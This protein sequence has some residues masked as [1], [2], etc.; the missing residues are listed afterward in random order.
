MKIKLLSLLLVLT[1]MSFTFKKEGFVLYDGK[2]VV[3]IYLAENEPKPLQIAARHLQDDIEMVTGHKP[4]IITNKSKLKGDVI[5]LSTAK[6]NSVKMKDNKLDGLY[7]SFSMSRISDFT[8]SVDDAILV[9][10]S[11]ALGAVYGT[12][13]ISEL[14]GVSPLYWW[15]DIKPERKDKVV[16]TEYTFAPEQPAVRYRAIFINDEEALIKW[17]GNTS[18]DKTK[19]AISPETYKKIF[20][21]MLRTRANTLWPSMMEAGS[22]FFE[23]KDENGIPI[24]PKNATDYGVYIGTSHCENMAR[25][26]YAEWYEW[27]E[28]HKELFDMNLNNRGELEFD[29]TVNPRAIEIYWRERIEES[30]NFNMIYTMGIRGVHDSPFMYRLMENPTLEKRVALLQKV[31]DFQRNMIKEVFGSEDAVPQ[32][33]VPYEETAELYNGESKDGKEKCES[34]K[35]PE[36]IMIV[37]TEDNYSYLRQLPKPEEVKRKGG[38]G[39]YYHLAYQ[40]YPSPY[41]WLTTIPYPNMQQE[42]K[43][44]YEAGSKKFWIVNVGDIKPC[45]V[46]L[47]LFIKMA[48]QPKKY[49]YEPT[50][51]YIKNT[52]ANMLNLDEQHTNEVADIVEKFQTL[53]NSNKPEFVTCFWSVYFQSTKSTYSFFSPFDFGDEIAQT[54]SAYKSLESRAK[55]VYDG[56]SE[57]RKAPFW[58][59]VYY[60][61]RAARQM[62]EKGYYYHKNVLYSEQG[63]FS[64]VNGYKALSERAAKEIDK[65]L[66][67]YNKEFLNGKWNGITDPYGD[68]NITERVFDIAGIIEH[69]IYKEKFTEESQ[70]ALG[71]VC[72]GQV[73]GKEQMVLRF[74]SYEDNKRFVDVFS[75]GLET[76]SWELVPSN[77]WI[78][79]NKTK[80]NVESEERLWVSIDWTK[81]KVG[82]N[83]GSISVKGKDGEVNNFEVSA[84]KFELS[85]KPKSYVE[86]AGFVTIEAEDYSSLRNGKGN[87]TWYEVDKLGYCGSS[88]V[89][90]SNGKCNNP[91]EEGA[92]LS[93]NVYFETAGEFTGYVYRIP[94]LNEGKGKTCNVAIGVDNNA[95]QILDGIRAKTSFKTTTMANG[96]KESRNWAKNVA[97]QMEKLPFVFKI[98][99][100]GYHT[101]SLYA[102]DNHIAVDRVVIATNPQSWTALSRSIVGPKQSYNNIASNYN[103]FVPAQNATLCKEDIK[104]NSYPNPQPLIYSKFAFSRYGNPEVWGFTP[105]SDMNIFKEGVNLYG[106]DKH[107]VKNVITGHNESTRIVPHWRRDNNRGNNPATFYVSLLEGNYEITIHSGMIRYYGYGGA[108]YDIHMNLTANGQ[109]LMNNEFFKLDAP[110][111]RT[112]NIKVGRDNLLKLDFSGKWCVSAIEIYRK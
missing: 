54:I 84:S 9:V 101:I 105:V 10:G 78:K 16:L 66:N 111:S 109:Q 52:Y 22:Y 6:N 65:D 18:I 106:W 107:N 76:Q 100:P 88:M 30:K 70:D 24:N 5:I 17:S 32:I 56:L 67:Y 12:F 64:A 87:A 75:K 27:A 31:I 79:I 35:L 102:V 34:L 15:G 44:V 41:D 37:Y 90:K 98:D 48:S 50:D 39:I 29:Y 7:E 1:L 42:L 89:V 103:K 8:P 40:G 99:K 20:E 82:T 92:T 112:Y 38:C 21:M 81:A 23:F 28:N 2:Q 43:K 97:T 96:K 71:S 57:N 19:G 55:R 60:P 110:S 68:Y 83:K 93:Y 73:N 61:I 72:E 25:N 47:N 13:Q 62:I 91:K 36:D 69:F 51:N 80:G 45:E 46:G 53:A 104:V 26:N 4:A 58:H 86:G 59:F 95:P 14:I 11:D 63:R 85:L 74:S 33:F 108:A 49:L 77:D 3:Q 94:T